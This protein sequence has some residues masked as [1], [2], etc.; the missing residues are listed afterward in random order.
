MQDV[1]AD[2]ALLLFGGWV[3][4][5]VAGVG[6]LRVVVVVAPF[7]EV[8]CEFEAAHVGVGVFEVDDDELF[9]FVGGEE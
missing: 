1:A 6:G 9:V 8:V 7:G 5:C 3:V 2:E 4:V